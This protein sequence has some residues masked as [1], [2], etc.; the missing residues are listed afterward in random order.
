VPRPN[1]SLV[2]TDRATLEKLLDRAQKGDTSTLPAVREMLRNPAVVDSFGGNL[3]Q[4][5]ELSLINAAAGTT[6]SSA[7]R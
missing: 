7:K 1:T 5:A 3:V 2:P 6:W 4:Q